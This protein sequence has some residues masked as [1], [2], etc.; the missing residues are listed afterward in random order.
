MECASICFLGNNDEVRM[1][2]EL[3]NL[4]LI[5]YEEDASMTRSPARA[6]QKRTED[7]EQG[8]TVAPSCG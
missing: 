8:P 2:M 5:P 3:L 6:C 4:Q 7:R 1:L